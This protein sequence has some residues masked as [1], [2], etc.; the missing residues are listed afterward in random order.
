MPNV[1]DFHSHCVPPEHWGDALWG[2][3]S[4]MKIERL[5]E[6][7]QQSQVILRKR[8]DHEEDAFLSDR[9]DF[10][11]LPADAAGSALGCGYALGA[12]R[13]RRKTILRN[14]MACAV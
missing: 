4:P 6:E 1:I 10:S 12:P 8:G 2:G 3:N 11:T 14:L 9:R 5:I 13:P 7:V